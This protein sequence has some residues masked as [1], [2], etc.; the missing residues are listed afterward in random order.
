MRDGALASGVGY[1]AHHGVEVIGIQS[2]GA[3]AMAR[4]WQQRKV[5]ADG[6]AGRRIATIIC[7]SNVAP[8][9]HA[10]WV[11]KATADRAH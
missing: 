5:I 4:S 7:G 11:L 1:V 10:C 6:V 8:A 2:L 3:P 9:D